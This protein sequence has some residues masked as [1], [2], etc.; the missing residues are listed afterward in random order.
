[1]LA[2][3]A[4]VG[5]CGILL[6]AAVEI[7]ARRRPV[8]R[9]LNDK[10]YAN[11][12]G[13]VDVGPTL[14]L[15]VRAAADITA[16]GCGALRRCIRQAAAIAAECRDD[17]HSRRHGLFAD[18]EIVVVTSKDETD[19]AVAAIRS[20][21]GEEPACA[22]THRVKFV[23]Y[24]QQGRISDV[25]AGIGCPCVGLAWRTGFLYASGDYVLLCGD[26]VVSSRARCD[27]ALT[28]KT[29]FKALRRE[30]AK[31][32]VGPAPLPPV[33]AFASSR[34]A[35]GWIARAA[36]KT[37][38]G[39]T[40]LAGSRGA[41]VSEAL[42]AGWT[43]A[44]L[45]DRRVCQPIVLSTRA[46]GTL[47]MAS[48]LRILTDRCRLS[49]V[50]KSAERTESEQDSRARAV[51]PSMAAAVRAIP[52]CVLLA[53]AYGTGRWSVVRRFPPAS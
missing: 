25:L 11:F 23:P 53:V 19:E 8:L 27:F 34:E 29:L 32:P 20:A 38:S 2:A 50:T 17:R 43:S 13:G 33:A 7:V 1:M 30:R 45:C 14:T 48:E 15:V 31:L 35:G 47:G 9:P 46:T 21:C 49:T 16:D 3:I 12:T 10:V 44:V 18:F 22:P 40:V 37:V 42:A 24:V 51:G 26:D 6:L 5:V 4:S 52:E 39:L 36:W 28:V 41:A